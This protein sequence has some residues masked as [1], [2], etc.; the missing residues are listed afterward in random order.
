MLVEGVTTADGDGYAHSKNEV[1]FAESRLLSCLYPSGLVQCTSN[2]R[3]GSLPRSLRK[4]PARPVAPSPP[5][6]GGADSGA[7]HCC[8][9]SS[10]ELPG[11]ADAIMKLSDEGASF[12]WPWGI[13]CCWTLPGLLPSQEEGLSVPHLCSLGCFSH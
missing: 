5:W 4:V 11:F 12:A 7:E 3:K 8:P 13:T 10:L 1:S 6:P 9:L 2:C